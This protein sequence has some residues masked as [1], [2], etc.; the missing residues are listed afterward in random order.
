MANQMTRPETFTR[1]EADT[2]QERLLDVVPP[3]P[4]ATDSSSGSHLTQEFF[5]DCR[6]QFSKL[7]QF[8]NAYVLVTRNLSRIFPKHE[9]LDPTLEA[10]NDIRDNRCGSGSIRALAPATRRRQLSAANQSTGPDRS[11]A[12]VRHMNA[13]PQRLLES[14]FV[15]TR[16][17]RQAVRTA[18]PQ[19]ANHHNPPVQYQSRNHY[20]SRGR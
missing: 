13:R 15:S 2:D 18:H 7:C 6:K 17:A 10:Q 11:F 4:F 16:S 9:H 14:R 8:D 1:Q 20:S 19:K 3:L 5:Y 12:P